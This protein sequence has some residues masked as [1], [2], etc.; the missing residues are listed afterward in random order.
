VLH[1]RAGVAADAAATEATGL[2]AAAVAAATGVPKAAATAAVRTEATGLHVKATA[3]GLL[4]ASQESA[5]IPSSNAEI[6]YAT[7]T[8]WT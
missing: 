1:G 7:R 3:A 8:T 6:T 4:A 5:A 2:Q